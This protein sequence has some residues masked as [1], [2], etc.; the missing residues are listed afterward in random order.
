MLSALSFQ[1]NIAHQ[2]I[3]IWR[4]KLKNL[5]I[6]FHRLQLS[7]V[8]TTTAIEE[9]Q[10]HAVVNTPVDLANH[11]GVEEDT[12]ATITTGTSRER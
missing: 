10:G 5:A 4:L 7:K 6:E 1:S 3:R 8:N 9:G 12:P 2:R 11:R